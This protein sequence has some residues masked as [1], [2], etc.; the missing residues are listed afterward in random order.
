MAGRIVVG[1]DGTPASIEAL[2]WAVQEA[3]R[4][5]SDVEAVGV[6]EVLT[7]SVPGVVAPV[8]TDEG[9]AADR[10]STLLAVIE[11]VGEPGLKVTPRVEEG[12]VGPVLVHVAADADLLV[13]GSRGLGT[14]RGLVGSVSQYVLRHAPC[15]VV[16]LPPNAEVDAERDTPGTT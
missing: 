14:V 11:T 3:A 2:Q 5:G 8:V 13:I 10:F 15:P 9:Q 7:V 16:V 12:A 4:R 6:W 1:V